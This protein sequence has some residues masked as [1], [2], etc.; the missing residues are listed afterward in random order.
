MCSHGLDLHSAKDAPVLESETITP[1]GT[2][3]L[4]ETWAFNGSPF[5]Q[6]LRLKPK[7]VS[8]HVRW[9]GSEHVQ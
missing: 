3:S 4:P 8:L 5:S 6:N 7:L 9:A 1:D 2:Q